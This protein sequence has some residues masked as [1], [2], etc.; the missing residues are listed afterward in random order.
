MEHTGD[1]LQV[2]FTSR[3]F[4]SRS[5]YRARNNNNKKITKVCS[6]FK[7]SLKVYISNITV[8]KNNNNVIS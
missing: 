4:A 2:I 6:L 8:K 5:M 7:V 3:L 1:R